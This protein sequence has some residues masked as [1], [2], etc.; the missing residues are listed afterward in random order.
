MRHIL[1]LSVLIMLSFLLSLFL[2]WH[3]LSAANF[4]YTA[5]YYWLDIDQ[6]VQ[7]FAPKN[8]FKQNFE[9][10]EKA[11]HVQLF[12]DI[13]KAINAQG[14][15]L[16]DL[17]YSDPKLNQ[18]TPLLHN[19]E[20]I[21]LQDVANLI[22][23]LNY[24]AAY[25]GFALVSLLMVLYHRGQCQFPPLLYSMGATVGICLFATLIIIVFGAEDL[26]YQW[27]TLVFPENHQWFFYY[28][29]SLMTTLMKAPDI[30]AYIALF[31]ILVTLIYH[32]IVLSLIKMLFTRKLNNSSR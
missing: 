18:K 13:V 26:F 22:A 6:T 24:I 28:H 30:F 9:L 29:E 16:A 27:H 1:K 17:S 10:T 5:L 11:D 25:L 3:T 21:H 4:G 20:I 12:H 14:S 8:Q 23:I 19:A 15:G 7:E 31:L 32:L 2:A